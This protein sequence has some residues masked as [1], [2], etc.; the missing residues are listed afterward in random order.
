MLRTSLARTLVFRRI[1]TS[2]SVPNTTRPHSRNDDS[3]HLLENR[4][5][6]PS[7]S[8]PPTATSD[9]T[10]PQN[11]LS[12]SDGPNADNPGPTYNLDFVKQR[13]REWSG[14]TAI[15]IRNRADD[16]T[17]NTKT[18][19]SQLGLHLNKVTG[20]EDIESLKRDVVDQGVWM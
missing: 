19:L 8:E 18:T 20:Y 14:Q 1:S 5:S 17:A 7:S 3:T 13:L 2:S 4:P 15:T 9:G 10:L 6:P 16:F 12:T 11:S